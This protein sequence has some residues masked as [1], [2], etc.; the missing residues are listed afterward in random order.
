MDEKQLARVIAAEFGSDVEKQT[1]EILQ[2]REKGAQP[3]QLFL[4]EALGVASLLISV[5]SLALQL[6]DRTMKRERL[7]ELL[8]EE[9]DK[10]PDISTE[11]RRAIIERVADN[12]VDQA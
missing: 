10:P 6:Y 7:I 2:T 12:V 1:E 3:R 4:A 9:A 8:D 5:A 11:T